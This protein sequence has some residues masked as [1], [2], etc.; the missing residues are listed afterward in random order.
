MNGR[1]LFLLST[2]EPFR[3]VE[4]DDSYYIYC[5]INYFD[6]KNQRFLPYAD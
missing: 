2:G 5:I 3:E 6:D 1:Y 4:S